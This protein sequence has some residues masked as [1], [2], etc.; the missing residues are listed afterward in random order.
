MSPIILRKI[1]KICSVR[2]EDSQDHLQIIGDKKED[3]L[4]AIEKLN[5]LEKARAY[6]MLSHNYLVLEGAIPCELCMVALKDVPDPRLSTTLLSPFSPY[7]RSLTICR[8]VVMV[9]NGMTCMIRSI[10]YEND[11]NASYLWQGHRLSIQSPVQDSSASSAISLWITNNSM[12]VTDPLTTENE[13]TTSPRQ[14]DQLA[15]ALAPPSTPLS[16][17]GTSTKKIRKIKGAVSNSQPAQAPISA[18]SS[19]R[20]S[21]FPN[22]VRLINV[23]NI[24]RGDRVDEP[25]NRYTTTEKLSQR[26]ANEGI[27]G[28]VPFQSP[29]SRDISC[30]PAFSNEPCSSLPSTMPSSVCQ[31]VPQDWERTS[32]PPDK[33][34]DIVLDDRHI[35][36]GRSIDN[37]QGPRRYNVMNQRKAQT[38]V[39]KVANIKESQ[40]T[41]T[42][43]LS[44]AV[45]HPAVELR[46]NIGRILIDR[47]TIPNNFRTG[48]FNSQ[49]WT[50]ASHGLTTEFTEMLTSRNSDAMDVLEL[51]GKHG[52]RVFDAA[53]VQRRVFYSLQ[54]QTKSNECL[55]IEIN[56]DKTFRIRSA[57]VL[58]G[59]VNWHFVQRAWDARV[60]LSSDEFIGGDYTQE[61]R[62]LLSSRHSAVRSVTERNAYD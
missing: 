50:D 33:T 40:Q 9:Q 5:V 39:T 27:P 35:S 29:V 45:L 55:S 56:E 60:V 37:V 11:Q 53:V 3:I 43:M 61:V 12:S 31:D 51:K 48:T 59:A 7:Y 15:D 47:S 16:T 18:K 62:T 36:K 25:E 46:V 32:V 6:R 30:Q 24:S 49:K 4:E 14:C 2:I 28:E 54:C 17:G 57:G 19:I 26:P 10:P 44:G 41:L 8:V 23:E 42:D 34:S 20:P 58:H 38:V 21:T 22:S 1:E 13:F 52:R